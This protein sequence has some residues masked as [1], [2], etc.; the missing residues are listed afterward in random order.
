MLE[1]MSP[2][3]YPLSS[4]P[5]ITE[6]ITMHN[7]FDKHKASTESRK[8]HEYSAGPTSELDAAITM[9]SPFSKQEACE[10]SH[11]SDEYDV[12]PGNLIGMPMSLLFIVHMFQRSQ[13]L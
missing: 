11:N 8:I 4:S 1:S 5:S 3:S 12:E 2:I 13:F 6:P 9:H 10:E 7:S